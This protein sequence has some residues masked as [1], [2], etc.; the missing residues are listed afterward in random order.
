MNSEELKALA[1]ESV[2]KMNALVDP[3]LKR[4]E[5]AEQMTP[6]LK[7]EIKAANEEFQKQLDAMNVRIQKGEM[8]P[9]AGDTFADVLMKNM[10]AE[11]V[12]SFKKTR[13]AAFDVENIE[14]HKKAGVVTRVTDTIQ[15]AFTNFIYDP[16][17]RFHVRD[18]LPVG[19]A[20]S[21]NIWMPYE[22]ATTNGIARVAESGAKPQSD[23]TPAVV[24]W[25]VEKIATYITF[26]EEILEDMPQFI[27]YLTTRWL[28]LLKQAEDTKLLYGTGSSDIKGLTVAAEAYSD[29]LASSLV[30]YYDV[31]LA[32][33]Y[34]VKGNDFTPNYV[35]IHPSDA[36]KVRTSKDTT[37]M[38]IFQPYYTNNGNMMVGGAQ[39]IETT[40][41]TEGDFLAGD[42]AMGAQIFDKKS[43]NISFSDQHSD[44]FIYNRITAVLEERLA[45]VTFHSGAFVFGDFA[46]ALAK[47]SA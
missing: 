6:E 4:I 31:L 35:L 15:P 20:T 38:P 33:V 41:M 7:A 2:Q 22:S 37:G 46:E 32:A 9:V 1:D 3:L 21:N 29:V 27:S 11:W 8:N 13:R 12:N 43:A 18:I 5:K 14:L 39:L 23:F 36:L 24:K 19:V 28:E 26:T 16:A 47:G 25:S 42:F 40:A 10:S 17:K 44:N 30:N 34:Q 45:L